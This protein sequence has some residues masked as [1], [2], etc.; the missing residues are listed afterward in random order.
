[1]VAGFRTKTTDSHLDAQIFSPPYLFQDG[2]RPKIDS[3][4]K[5][6]IEC[7][8]TFNIGTATPN[9][10]ETVCLIALSTVTHSL[11]TG[12]RRIVL[13]KRV[14]NGTLE[15]DAPPNARSCP[16]GYYMLFILNKNDFPSEAKIVRIVPRPEAQIRHRQF[17]AQLLSQDFSPPTARD[18]RDEVRD[19]EKTREA[20][21]IELGI[22]PICPYGLSGCWGGA[23]DALSQLIGVKQVDPIPHASGSTAS[24]FL[25]ENTLPDLELWTQQFKGYVDGTY[26]LRGFEAAIKGKVER[27]NNGLV[28]IPVGTEAEVVLI[29]LQQGSKIQLDT[30]SGQSQA[31]T[32]E[33]LNAY[34]ELDQTLS[35]KRELLVTVTGP[36]SQTVDVHSLQV[37]K[38]DK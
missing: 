29:P 3:V 28:V 18:L 36:L 4:S 23:Y 19:E 7:G 9:Q 26:G 20:I 24:V 10:I 33:E 22:T 5:E 16:P 11:N 31:A 12:Q 13:D 34:E 15:V 35:D 37:R 14:K 2:P 38:V 8:T 21:R 25:A 30:G 17:T 32:N 27:R 1:M 6:V